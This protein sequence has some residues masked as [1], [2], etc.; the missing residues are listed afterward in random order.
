MAHRPHQRNTEKAHRHAAPPR[1]VNQAESVEP[2]AYSVDQAAAAIGISRSTFSRSVLPFV[3]TIETK[4]GQRLVA[5]DELKRYVAER[6]QPAKRRPRVTSLGRPPAVSRD[7]AQRIQAEHAAGK[8]LGQIARDLDADHV[9]TA[10]GGRRWWPSSV[11][12]VL[13]RSSSTLRASDP[14]PDPLAARQ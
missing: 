10:Q 2:L 14:E 11:R 1:T 9:P 7:I 12:A 3:E 8:T 4:W 13:L 5:I 6:R